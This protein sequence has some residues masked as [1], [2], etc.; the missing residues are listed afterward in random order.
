MLAVA[1][2]IFVILT[3]KDVGEMKRAETRAATEGKIIRDG[4]VPMIAGEITMM[5]A[6]AGATPKARNMVLPLA[7]LVL[8][9]PIFMLYTGWSQ[10]GGNSFFELAD[11]ASGSKSVL[12]V[13]PW[14]PLQRFRHGAICGGAS[15]AI[16]IACARACAYLSHQCFYSLLN[17]D[18]LGDIC[19]Y[20]CDCCAALSRS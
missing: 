10:D 11:R 20:D 14:K 4:A 19:D 16:S 6:K 12:Y 5:E 15:Q 1:L 13:C 9:M 3:G 2:V 7:A 18:E 17:R 8:L